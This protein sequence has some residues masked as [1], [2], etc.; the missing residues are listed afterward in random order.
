[1]PTLTCPAIKKETM[2]GVDITYVPVLQ[3]NSENPDLINYARATNT[4]KAH[5]AFWTQWQQQHPQ[6]TTREEEGR[7]CG[8]HA[9]K[10]ITALLSAQQHGVTY[11]TL[12]AL[13]TQLHDR[14]YY[15]NTIAEQREQ[16][17]QKRT[18]QINQLSTKQTDLS[19]TTNE[20]RKSGLKQ[21]W[22]KYFTSYVNPQTGAITANQLGAG[23]MEKLVQETAAIANN[24]IVVEDAKYL[25]EAQQ[26]RI[27]QFKCSPNDQ[28]AFALTQDGYDHWIS[29]AL[30]KKDEKTSALVTNSA[31]HLARIQSVVNNFLSKVA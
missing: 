26:E 2:S 31:E 1:M 3:Q 30:N 18:A 29:I 9:L 8:Y 20:Q 4:Q 11:H 14:G 27:I 13:C 17:I 5:K 10:N 19:C 21:S 15:A 6:D 16:I 28:L 22:M 12:P 7:N 24:T 25:T 23:E